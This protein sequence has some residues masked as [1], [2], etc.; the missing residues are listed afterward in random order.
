M[1]PRPSTQSLMDPCDVVLSSWM[2]DTSCTVLF[3][4]INLVVCT[5]NMGGVFNFF[6]Y[7]FVRRSTAAPVKKGPGATGSSATVSTIA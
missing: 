7:T 4:Q 6:A 3:F 1:S 5:T 2:M